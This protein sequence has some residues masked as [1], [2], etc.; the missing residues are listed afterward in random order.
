MPEPDDLWKDVTRIPGRLRNAPRRKR[1]S[2]FLAAALVLGCLLT[3]IAGLVYWQM[4]TD[5]QEVTVAL[6]PVRDS[7]AAVEDDEPRA[8][9]EPAEPFREREA[10]SI[11][12]PSRTDSSP[13][14]EARPA[15]NSA[16]KTPPPRVAAK[17]PPPDAELPPKVVKPPLEVAPQKERETAAA[18]GRAL[19][20][21]AANHTRAALVARDLDEAR[22][23]LD[24][25]EKNIRLPEQLVEVKQLRALA[26]QL[27]LFFDAVRAGW[28]KFQPA[29]EVRIDG[30]VAAV[31]EARPDRLTLFVEGSQ[32]S[33][34]I[35]TMP[36]GMVLFF[37]RAG[38]D[39]KAP[40]AA[41]FF[42]AFYA[43][44]PQGDRD[45]A[46]QSWQRAAA[47]GLSVDDLLPLVEGP[48]LGSR[49][50]GVPDAARVEAAAKQLQGRLADLIVSAE[51]GPR[52][53]LV[54]AKMLEAARR[55]DNS[56]EQYAALEQ[57][58]D[59]A[60]SAGDPAAALAAL[61]ELGRWF[62]GDWLALKSQALGASLAGRVTSESAAGAAASAMALSA[63]AQR[64]GRGE[65]ALTLADTAYAAA[66]KA[67]DGALVKR[68]YQ[69]RTEVQAAEK[70]KS[71]PSKSS[72]AKR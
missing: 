43:I 26:E 59:W 36:S 53:S 19:F 40:P 17:Q 61:D 57:A 52:K 32:R 50:E 21:R 30:L 38:A 29:E 35:A 25:A 14:T 24:V 62:D 63:E 64:A 68:A 41:V 51:S 37:A 6:H 71:R 9:S 60:V 20:E 28:Q 54:A 11:S 12:P 47:A 65:L 66:R 34:T 69:W 2:G 33:Y 13:L 72:P 42:G 3:A 4:R 16:Q 67:G 7:G 44:D 70:S 49:R 5:R 10:Q 8:Q 22:R 1:S 31:V 56:A 27:A 15:E 48:A 55:A 18:E 46:R 39:E 45:K 23:Q 58:R